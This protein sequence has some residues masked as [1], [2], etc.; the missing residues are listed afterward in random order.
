[1]KKIFVLCL[2]LFLLVAVATAQEAQKSE[3]HQQAESALSNSHPITPRYTF[4][5]AYEDY[6]NKGKFQQGLECV[7]KA[8]SLHI[9]EN[10]YK[11]AFDLLTN[12]DQAINGKPQLSDSQKDGLHYQVSKERMNI[13]MRLRRPQSVLEHINQMERYAERSGN[14][15]LKNDAL[16]NKAIYYYTFGDNAKGN[17]VFKEMANKLTASKEYDKVDKVYQTLIDNSRR[18]NNASL[19]AQSYKSYIAWNDSANA[20]KVADEI[21]ALKKQISDSEAAIEEKDSSLILLNYLETDTMRMFLVNKQLD[22]IWTSKAEATAYPMSQIPPRMEK[23]DGFAWFERIRPVDKYDIFNWRGK[24][25]GSELKASKQRKA[26]LQQ[27]NTIK[28]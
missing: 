7:A 6:F 21:N 17:A 26:P 18:S 2:N 3:L 12:A 27:L 20:L 19:L 28:K 1:M 15:E 23:L 25:K 10:E 8:A 13:Y 4:V 22:K 24:T 11:E 14:E 16:Y 9:S 5:R